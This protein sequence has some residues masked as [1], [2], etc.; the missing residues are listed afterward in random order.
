MFTAV[1][2]LAGDF[3]GDDVV[4]VADD[5]VRRKGLTTAKYTQ[6]ALNVWRGNFG[7][8]LGAGSGAAIPSAT[9]LSP[10]VPEPSA[11]FLFTCGLAALVATRRVQLAAIRGEK[12]QW[13]KRTTAAEVSRAAGS[14]EGPR[15]PQ[16]PVE[17]TILCDC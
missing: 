1:S 15:P 3:N 13:A 17:K 14:L 6:A 8:T 7:A 10:A 9:P 12:N 4:D 11:L 5:V 16:Q 2:G